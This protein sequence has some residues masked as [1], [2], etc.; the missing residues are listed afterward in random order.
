MEEV[1]LWGVPRKTDLVPG[2]LLSFL[3]PD[4]HEVSKVAPS[5]P[6]TMMSFLT[7]GP[8]TMEPVGMD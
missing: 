8:E 1:G 3:L 2:P 4:C 5:Q 6:S 7:T